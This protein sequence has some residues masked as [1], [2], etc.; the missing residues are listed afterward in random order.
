MTRKC[1]LHAWRSPAAIESE[2]GWWCIGAKQSSRMLRWLGHYHTIIR[3]TTWGTI[4]PAK[5][6]AWRSV[7]RRSAKP[8][9]WCAKRVHGSSRTVNRSTALPTKRICGLT[10]GCDGSRAWCAKNFGGCRRATKIE[11]L[12][13]SSCGRRRAER[14]RAWSCR[15][16]R[17]TKYAC[18]IHR[19]ICKI[20]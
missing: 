3:H 15:W 18:W 5:C 20:E 2:R 8:S 9:G 10:K 19:S 13:R 12:I 11:C 6:K 1:W 14:E 16:L 4:G 7:I 17:L